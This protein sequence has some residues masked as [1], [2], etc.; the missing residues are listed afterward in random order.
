MTGRA[1]ANEHENEYSDPDTTAEQIPRVLFGC[2][3]HSRQKRVPT[4]A[5]ENRARRGP[6]G[7]NGVPKA[8][9][10]YWTSRDGDSQG[11][12]IFERS[13]EAPRKTGL[14]IGEALAKSLC[15]NEQRGGVALSR[16]PIS[17]LHSK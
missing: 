6:R 2:S 12:G 1:V 16:C 13:T 15:E 3:S 8:Q 11:G 14:G 5:R 9:P 17:R 4:P 7:A 10:N